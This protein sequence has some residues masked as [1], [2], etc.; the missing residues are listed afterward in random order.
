M[1]TLSISAASSNRRCT[2]S[3]AYVSSCGIRSHTS[4]R[5]GMYTAPASS[6]VQSICGIILGKPAKELGLDASLMDLGIDSLGFAELVLQ[7]ERAFG[8]GVITVDD[9][10]DAP[11]IGQ[12]AAKLSGVASITVTATAPTAAGG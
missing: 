6:T 3:V 7:L 11:S 4:S 5:R 1:A 10:M 2:R 12:I 8:D 9:I